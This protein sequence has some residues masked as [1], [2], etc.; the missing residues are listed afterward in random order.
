M[1]TQ[2][3]N[4]PALIAYHVTASAEGQNANWTRIGAAWK[5]KKGGFQIKLSV[6]PMN[7]ELVLLPPRADKAKS[8][9]PVTA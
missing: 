2:T 1:S 4:A 3:K 5:N 9:A 8:E 6:V 7:G